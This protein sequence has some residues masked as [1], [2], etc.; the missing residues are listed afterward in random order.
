MLVVKDVTKTYS[1][2][3]GDPVQALC[4]V[5]L[6]FGERGMYFLLGKSGSGKSTLLNILGGLDKAD[7]GEIFYDGV[8]FSSFSEQDF[9]DYRN[10]VVGFVF[11]EY[12]LLENFTA[13]ENVALALRMQGKEVS[14]EEAEAALEKVGLAGY[15]RRQVSELSGGQKQRVAIAR[16]IVKDS[17]LILADE[18]TGNLDSETGAEIFG[19]LRV[20][21]QE[22]TVI[23]VS[24]DRENAEK[25][26]DAVIELK[27]GRVQA[28][29]ENVRQ[30]VGEMPERTCKTR[31]HTRLP[32]SFAAKMARHNLFQKKWRSLLTVLAT[33][34]S[35]M[36]ICLAQ[37]FYAADT[38]RNI[39][40]S[41]EDLGKEYLS[42]R[43]IDGKDSY[44]YPQFVPHIDER[45]YGYL[46]EQGVTPVRTVHF[47]NVSAFVFQDERQMQAFGV[48][49]YGETTLGA[50][51][52]Y[53]S[54]RYID[55]ALSEG[56]WFAEGALSYEEMAGKELLRKIDISYPSE[57]I[58]VM[59]LRIAGVFK[60]SY[61]SDGAIGERMN[62]EIFRENLFCSE[63]YYRNF[64]KTERIGTYGG[65]KLTAE[66]ETSQ[67]SFEADAWFS[68][69]SGVSEGGLYA[70]GADGY[71]YFTSETIGKD[72]V[73]LSRR[74]Y[75]AL[76]GQ[77]LPSWPQ[78]MGA[79]AEAYTNGGM[80]GW[81]LADTVPE[82]IGERVDFTAEHALTGEEV[83]FL[84]GKKI[85]G[86]VFGEGTPNRYWAEEGINEAYFGAGTVSGVVSYKY[87]LYSNTS[88][89]YI[90]TQGATQTEQILQT[91]RTDFS[92]GV[93]NDYS[94]EAPFDFGFYF[95]MQEGSFAEMRRG[96]LLISAAS[97]V[98]AMLLLVALISFGISSRK[99]EI[100]ILKALGCGNGDIRKIY[101][102][103][104]FL[105]G[106]LTLFLSLPAV[107]FSVGW[108]NSDMCGNG[109]TGITYI[110]T[111]AVTWLLAAGI[112][113]VAVLLFAYIPLCRISRM[114]PADAIRGR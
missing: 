94:E 92:M 3:K 22:K 95:Y 7:G 52:Y 114:K 4:G 42:L 44:G 49:F 25:Y 19:L 57:E 113:V 12:N 43:L 101:V 47:N 100:G 99:K 6:T 59:S 63:T 54:D 8:P 45:A 104:A 72:E 15:G 26:G 60:T 58:P 31:V 75:N 110:M 24:H 56:A 105:I 34:L 35:V 108:V 16:A 23:V 88:G 1:A 87:S 68:D 74:M 36:V 51:G 55:E 40:R 30:V 80:S 50:E 79:Y 39:A 77:E 9:S 85:A 102:F 111:D 27:D 65:W 2:K 82:H 69:I 14:D 112:S 97:F 86:V 98:I 32:F 93:G 28:G 17:A 109:L 96:F 73:L 76:F 46:Q 70:L 66:A 64:A 107:F 84:Q 21:A 53:A 29:A 90:R 81:Y 83:L 33:A 5:T 67:K 38:E 106:M 61:T 37:V 103:E 48:Q 13:A 20:L 10:G 78:V 41:A 71:R 89:L 62:A 11:Q 91:L 18:P